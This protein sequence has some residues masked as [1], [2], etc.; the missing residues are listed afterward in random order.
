MA[1]I[2]KASSILP[3]PQQRQAI[4]HVH[5]PMLVVAGAGTGK[6]T[7]LIQRIARLIRE[8]NAHPNEIVALTYTDNAAAQMRSRLAAEL[9]RREIQG[10]QVCTFHAYCN[11]LLI[12]ADRRFGVL[13][14]KQLWIF[15]RRNLREL[16]LNY[17]V[18][19]ANVSK[20]L[21]DLL[22][23]IRRCHDELV[24]P[25]DYRNY[26]R[27]IE[28]GELPLPRVT[29]S[30]D[31]DEISEEEIL[32][33]CREIAFVFETVERT[34]KERNLGTFNHMI[35]RANE[36]LAGNPDVL[37]QARRRAK[38]ILVDEFQDANYAQIE[39]LSKVAGREASDMGAGER[40]PRPNLFAVG[41][42]DQGIYRFRGASSEAFDLFLQRF[43]DATLVPLTLNRRSTAPILRC[44]YEVIDKNPE[45][46]SQSGT[47]Y[48]RE[49]LV[50][51]RDKQDPELASTR[52]P[53]EAVLVTGTFMEA[54]DLVATLVERRKRF[55]CQWKDIAVLYRI[56]GHREEVA[57]ELARNG[58]PFS[59]EAMD[60]LDTPEVRDLLACL[61]SVFIPGDSA[62]LFRVVALPR[63]DCD[64]EVLRSGMKSLPRDSTAGL[65][66]VLP[67]V[68]GGPEVLTSIEQARVAVRG[69]KANAA[70]VSL[71]REFQLRSN[72]AID[73][74]LEF[75]QKWEEFP[76]TES[77]GPLEF[78]EYLDYFRE[79]RGTVPLALA[80]EE[81][82]VK[83]M[84]VHGAK[85]LEY[86]HVF[87]LRA[88]KPS[89]P[90]A[91]RESLVDFPRELR[92]STSFSAFDDKT[93]SEHE[94]RR[95]FYVAMTRARDSLTIYAPFGRGEKDKTPPGFLRE[96]LKARELKPVLRERNCREF[97]TGIFARE[98]VAPASRLSE[99]VSMP[100]A[101]DLAHTLSASAIDNY[102]LCPLRFKLD[103]EWRIPGE[104]SAALQYGASMH[105]VLR[106]Y[107]DSVRLG[108]PKSETE[109]LQV[110]RDD[111]RAEAIAD[112]YQHEL[113]EQQGIA[114]LKEFLSS[115]QQ[116][117]IQVLHTE[118]YFNIH[119]GETTLVGRIDR[120]DQ[121]GEGGVVIV[122]YKTGKPKSQE[123]ADESLQLSLYALAAREK[124]GYIP[125]R[126]AFH[127]LD[128]NTVIST[129]RSA[130]EL[131]E[132]RNQVEKIAAKIAQGKFEPRLGYH[133]NSCA[134]RGICP[135][136]EKRVPEMAVAEEQVR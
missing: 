38:F 19:A 96:L 126:L 110:F 39:V 78:L 95:L 42:P 29:K 117:P 43:P 5:G 23:F 124:W 13:D 21:D 3:D 100:P 81:N 54:T 123:D 112:P 15:L 114:Q 80:D 1:V 68:P 86:Q 70:L 32:G 50:S 41:D 40:P 98:E 102:K 92:N 16:K 104:V 87:L 106:T 20:F 84:T 75:A 64:P 24:T 130:I 26:L 69:L 7:V 89:F 90:A 108:R 12:A 94:E 79:A 53:V 46:S 45:I 101:S 34:L 55:R 128:G 18:R 113:Y 52:P 93:L 48:R 127:N 49:P 36:L 11:D 115:A 88:T 61:S 133:C 71:V 105:R 44:A 56:H 122:D 107:Y 30:K 74:I 31:A 91:Y 6:T 111:L 67:G 60:V 25:E 35:V 58:V 9:G 28:E 10:L 27:R 22:D 2:R 37:V 66:Q 17:F 33:R 73:A 85:G 132:A 8:G 59:I 63:F 120:M 118:E 121:G 116:K 65:L 125:E 14:D 131:E 83:L 76:L 72:S 82:S 135:K 51:A 97:Q 62:S 47:A 4:E 57:H 129:V 134:Y 103:R 119:I 136:T 77:G 109:L 99:W